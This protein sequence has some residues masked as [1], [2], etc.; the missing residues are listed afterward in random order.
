MERKRALYKTSKVLIVAF[1]YDVSRQDFESIKK[2]FPDF[3]YDFF[4]SP[5]R[6]V[7]LKTEIGK[8]YD[9]IEEVSKLPFVETAAMIG[10][11]GE[12]E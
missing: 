8:E 11:I 1:N 3:T 9:A 12:S 7:N 4:S 2:Q 10:I 6:T 5:R